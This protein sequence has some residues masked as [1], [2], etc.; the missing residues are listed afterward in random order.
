MFVVL[1]LKPRTRGD[2]SS[3]ASW[4]KQSKRGESK[5]EITKQKEQGSRGKSSTRGGGNQPPR[6]TNIFARKGGGELY[7]IKADGKYMIIPS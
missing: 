1:C 5:G 4:L 2:P 3:R 6:G 7:P